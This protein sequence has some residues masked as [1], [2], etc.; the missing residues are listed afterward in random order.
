VNTATAEQLPLVLDISEATAQ[1]LVKYRSE[2]GSFKTLEK[3][4]RG[5]EPAKLEARKQRAVF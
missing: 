3:K 5:I 1:A 4:V 2:H